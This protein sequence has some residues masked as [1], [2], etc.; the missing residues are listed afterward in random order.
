MVREESEEH[1]VRRLESFADIV[2]GFSLAMLTLNLAIPRHGAVELFTSNPWPLLGFAATFAFVAVFWW[3]SH[4]L[5]TY[6]FVPT[7]PNI[8]L[9]FVTLAGILF[10]TYSLQLLLHSR[11]KDPVAYAM[12]LGTISFVVLI[13]GGL[14]LYGI[15]KRAKTMTPDIVAKGVRRGIGAVLISM[16]LIPAAFVTGTRGLHGAWGTALGGG[17]VF[18]ALLSRLL[19][20]AYLAKRPSA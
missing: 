10:F 1:V 8:V 14:T 6:Y 9:T 2:I 17:L 11:M 18:A 12:Y 19:T 20:R 15:G 13:L 5:F 4:R 16:V 7:A 3:S